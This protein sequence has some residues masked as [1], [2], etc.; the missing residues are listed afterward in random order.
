V[1]A[2]VRAAQSGSMAQALLFFIF[3]FMGTSIWFLPF[4]GIG[5]VARNQTVMTVARMAMAII[6]LYYLCMGIAIL[7]GSKTYG[8]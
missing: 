5:C 2:G 3:F 7:M 8:Y 6:A 1:A 4:L